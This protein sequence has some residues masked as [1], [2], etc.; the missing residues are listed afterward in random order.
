MEE[1]GKAVRRRAKSME[2]RVRARQ[3]LEQEARS[4]EHG[5]W[6]K[7]GKRLGEEQRAKSEERRA[8]SRE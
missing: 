2:Q 6:R 4:M 1:N 7:T 3:G 8:G 5:A